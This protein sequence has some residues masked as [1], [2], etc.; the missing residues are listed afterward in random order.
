MTIAAASV[1]GGANATASLLP[2][3]LLGL[4]SA[5]ALAWPLREPL[6]MRWRRGRIARRPFPAEWRD[7]LR[8][9]V[10]LVQALPADLQLRLK[11]LIQVFLAEKPFIG[12]GGLLVSEEMRVTV[13]AQAC[14]LRLGQRGPLAGLDL[15]PGLR[16]I[17]LYP[18]PFIVEH[19]HNDGVLTRRDRSVRLGESSSQGQVVLSWPDVLA[20]AADPADGH[21]VV[22]HEF[23]HQLDQQGGAFANGA[24]WLP[25]GRR[26][27]ER[28]ARVLGDEFAAL[29]RRVARGETGL[30]D[31]YGAQDAAEF[32]AVATEAYF[33]QPAQ[34]AAQHPA[35]F[36]ELCACYR[37]KPLSW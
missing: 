20:G 1:T 17:L 22:L 33:E 18:A 10:P 9:R 23:A 7:I 16:Q 2:P 19:E 3:L 5:A 36:D 13:A 26:R 14:L 24:P 29:R 12:C 27:R 8:R 35:L 31:A 28:W 4:G 25:G 6:A 34:L 15:F 11:K 30:L 32:F 21:N 37:L